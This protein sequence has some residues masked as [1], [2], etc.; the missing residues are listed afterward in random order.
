MIMLLL[1]PGCIFPGSTKPVIKVGLIAPFEGE[2]RH[3]GYQRLYGV[4]LA[5]QEANTTGGIAGYK[6][7]LVALNDYANSEETA[8]QSLELIADPDVQAVIGQWD[9]QLWQSSA[10]IYGKAH[11]PVINPVTFTDYALLPPHFKQHFTDLAGTKPN[12]Q[13]QQAYLATQYLLN[14]VGQSAKTLGSPTRSNI[15]VY[16]Q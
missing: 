11:M 13:A 12:E 1:W 10:D 7:E 14:L 9:A 16:S 3:H 5:L 2:L 6:V 15:W 4:K 8:L